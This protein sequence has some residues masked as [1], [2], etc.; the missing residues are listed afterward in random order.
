MDD[1]DVDDAQAQG[2]TMINMNLNENNVEEA[3]MWDF[4]FFNE[5]GV[6]QY[7]NDITYTPWL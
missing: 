4:E 6:S 3:T 7:D 2:N 5:E 1:E